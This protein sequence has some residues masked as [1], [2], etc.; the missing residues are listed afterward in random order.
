MV[1]K[2]KKAPYFAKM[3][4]LLESCPKVLIVSV[5]FVGS[6]QMQEIRIALR[7]KATILMGKNTMI[8][9]CLRNH[10]QVNPS[11]GLEQLVEAVGGNTGFVFCHGDMDEIRKICEENTVAKAAKAGVMA[12]SDVELPQGPT[13]L[14]PSST[15]FFQIL[16]I[17]TKIVKGTIELTTN[18]KVCISGSKVSA[19]QAVLLQKMGVKP[20]SFGMKITKVFDNGSVFDAAVLD[21]TD[22][23]VVGKFLGAMQTMAALSREVG[24]PTEASLPHMVG[25]AVKNMA[26]LCA[27]IDFTFPEI[28]KLKDF[29]ADPSAFA[30][31]V[32]ADAPAAGGGAAPAAAAAAPE[33][34]EEEEDM[35]FDLFG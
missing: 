12:P 7:G 5:D 8:R 15:N 13:G 9:T 17:P 29:L 27:E 4:E 30:S 11:L 21:I 22:E 1:V 16:N 6:K 34:E 26:A 18:V 25:G 2:S 23:V 10:A 20:F 32:V 24:I 3:V 35:D 33:P 14:D 31:A 19:S 28:Q